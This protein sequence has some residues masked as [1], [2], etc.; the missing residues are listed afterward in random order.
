LRVKLVLIGAPGDTGNLGVSALQRSAL[1]GVLRRV[2]DAEITVFDN[3][4]GLRSAQVR[5]DE[6]DVSYRCV[7][8]RLS[9]RWYR[10]ESLANVRVSLALRGLANPTAKALLGADVV[11]DVSGGDSF[12]DL[13]GQRRFELVAV[14]M[15]LALAQG[16]PLVLLPQTYGPFANASNQQRARSIIRQAALAIARDADSYERL[17]ALTDDEED[18]R[19]PLGARDEPRYVSGV[20]LAFGLESRDPPPEVIAGLPTGEARAPVIGLNISGLVYNDPL[21]SE[22]F[23]FRASY[24]DVVHQLLDRLLAGSPASVV[25]VPH[26]VTPPDNIESDPRACATVASAFPAYRDRLTVAP[27]LTDPSEVKGLISRFD[28]FCGTR[29]HATIAA[30]ST[31]VPTASIAY[32]GKAAGVFDTCDQAEHVADLRGS[33]TERIVDQVWE[34]WSDR[35]RARSSLATRLPM[36]LAPADSQLDRIVDLCSR[37]SQGAPS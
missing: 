4:T 13:Y 21:S 31:G 22:R 37:R 1:T 20:D 36:V 28:W 10:P 6:H 2:P 16:K 17:Q 9:R 24:R 5:I 32:S 7:G 3:G 26:V 18:G 19:R 12:S 15:E 34:S 23:G 11:L 14:P 35:A 30:L 25:L 8:A 27:T 33:T 29:M